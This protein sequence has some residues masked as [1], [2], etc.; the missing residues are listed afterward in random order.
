LPTSQAWRG[1][2]KGGDVYLFLTGMMVL[3]EV[4]RREG[5]FDW[6]AALAVRRARGS[7]TRL[8]V[9]I[10]LVGVA[11]TA[12]LSNDATA[13]VLT[14][15]VYATARAAKAPALP[16]L[17][18]CAMV[19]NA[20][21]FVLPI[22]NPA[23]LI[24]F[25]DRIPPIGAWLARFGAASL[26]SILVTFAVL[27]RLHRGMLQ[28]AI[29]ADVEVRKLSFGGKLAGLGIAVAGTALTIASARGL[30]LGLATFV[31]GISTAA[32]IHIAERKGPFELVRIIAWSVLPLVAGLFVL[33]EALEGIGVSA[34]L[35]GRLRHF[36]AQSDLATA[37]VSGTI[38]AV[39]SNLVNNLPAG[40][41]AGATVQGAHASEKISA[42]VLVGVDLGP[43]LSVTG[44]LATILWLVAIRRE[45]ETVSAWTFLKL[46]VVVMPAALATALLGV[47]FLG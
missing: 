31:A 13:V 29:R 39:C 5:L 2:I 8:Y 34:A 43:N 20:A 12:I 6:L 21:S 9:L 19:A 44:S 36:A 27:R 15:A 32:V 41:L 38:V 24:V 40:L 42:A 4:A 14:P 33:V 10:Y 26:L 22:S 30:P 25:A 28:D 3:A 47:L 45:G 46:G 1:V 17:F 16:Y 37:A 11:V 18:V 23:N 35:S 7:P